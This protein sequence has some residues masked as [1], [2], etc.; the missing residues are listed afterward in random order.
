MSV[1]VRLDTTRLRR[2]AWDRNSGPARRAEDIAQ[3]VRRSAQRRAPVQSGRLRGSIRVEGPK[4]G[5]TGL[6]WDVVAPVPYAQWIVTGRR[7]DR[8]VAGGVVVATAGPR[9]FLLEAL[10]EVLG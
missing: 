9:P 4:P 6:A 2:L 1:E 5:T 3:R 10:R 7:R 8:R